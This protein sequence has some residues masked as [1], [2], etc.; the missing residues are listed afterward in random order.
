MRRRPAIR[1]VGGD[2]ALHTRGAVGLDD[3]PGRPYLLAGTTVC[4]VVEDS[5][6]AAAVLQVLARGADVV[7]QL[8]LPDASAFLDS[9]RRVAAVPAPSSPVLDGDQRALLDLLA[10]GHTAGDAARRLGMSLRTAHR[11][12]GGARAVL[13]ATSNA[14]AIARLGRAGSA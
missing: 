3:V 11:R 2:P 10:R 13:G 1:F 8:T 7:A 5:E 9:V 12:L 4:A 6:T 14:E